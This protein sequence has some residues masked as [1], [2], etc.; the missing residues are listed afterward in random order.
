MAVRQL[1]QFCAARV[2]WYSFH[3]CTSDA[4]LLCSQCNRGRCPNVPNGHTHAAKFATACSVIKSEN[5]KKIAP[6]QRLQDVSENRYRSERDLNRQIQTVC[7]LRFQ[8]VNEVTARRRHLSGYG[9]IGMAITRRRLSQITEALACCIQRN[10]TT[11]KILDRR[12]IL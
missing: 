1:C 11:S 8:R 3:S 12:A 6:R 5:D 2:T 4:A 9:G 10:G 7:D